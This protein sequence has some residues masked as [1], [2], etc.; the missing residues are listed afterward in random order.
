MDWESG[1]F[2]KLDLENKVLIF[3]F[4]FL[5]FEGDSSSLST[6]GDVLGRMAEAVSEALSL[7][8]PLILSFSFP[9]GFRD[10]SFTDRSNML[11]V[12]LFLINWMSTS[13]SPRSFSF[14]PGLDFKVYHLQGEG[15]EVTFELKSLKQ[16]SQSLQPGPSSRLLQPLIQTS[17]L[18]WGVK[19]RGGGKDRTCSFIFEKPPT[20][21]R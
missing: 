5:S 13:I 12:M 21:Q 14:F 17:Y 3:D 10:L 9:N 7:F 18:L 2:C 11:A 1:V 8:F 15:G 20:R 16:R 6:E 4:F 19:G